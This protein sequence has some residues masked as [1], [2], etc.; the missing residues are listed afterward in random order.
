MIKFKIK[1]RK[2]KL[3]NNGKNKEFEDL[4]K[5]FNNK[6]CEFESRIYS[7]I[8]KLY[9]N[10]N[11]DIYLKVENIDYIDEKYS[12]I[13]ENEEYEDD[14]EYIGE[15]YL[16]LDYFERKEIEDEKFKGKIYLDDFE[17]E[18]SFILEQDKRYINEYK[19]LLEI[20]C[21]NNI[22]LKYFPKYILDRMY[23][24]KIIDIPEEISYSDFRYNKN[25]EYSFEFG[26]FEEIVKI[27]K[28]VYWNIKKRNLI[29]NSRVIP[30]LDN[31]YFE[32][33]F[34]IESQSKYLLSEKENDVFGILNKN[35][36]ISV[37][38]NSKDKKIWNFYQ[39]IELEE[40]EKTIYSN[41]SCINY[42]VDIFNFNNVVNLIK[43]IEILKNIDIIE[44]KENESKYISF[45]ENDK[46]KMIKYI[47]FNYLSDSKYI[48]DV[49]SYAKR[50]IEEN[51]ENY[52]VRVVSFE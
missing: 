27:N 1:E 6:I 23:R 31:I 42:G 11:L 38:S 52:T 37:Y 46:N 34:K 18:F 15:V 33:N 26:K 43:S 47:K 8:D 49:L 13:I 22:K 28:F 4:E 7:E 40:F 19:K 16:E 48:Y 14:F 9:K 5:Y 39:I 30:T 41:V 51:F 20:C 12:I 29:S 35:N 10:K 2:N 21:I 32:H 45:Y 17:Y 50:V 3:I 44:I 25:V 24:I 36:L